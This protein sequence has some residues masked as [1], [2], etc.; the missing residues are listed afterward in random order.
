MPNIYSALENENTFCLEATRS[1]VDHTEGRQYLPS[2]DAPRR[3]LP[4]Q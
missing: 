4:R 3:S 1:T 2:C